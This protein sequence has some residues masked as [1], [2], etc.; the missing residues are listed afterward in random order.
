M[1]EKIN[2]WE[3]PQFYI[4]IVEKIKKS[5]FFYKISKKI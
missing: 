4:L 2:K 5:N 1:K 3:K